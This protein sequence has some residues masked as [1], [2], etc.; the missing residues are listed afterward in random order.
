MTSKYNR[1]IEIN[2][3]VN[4]SAL[5]NILECL[6]SSLNLEFLRPDPSSNETYGTK[7]NI[8]AH[9]YISNDTKFIKLTNTQRK[10]VIAAINRMELLAA[11]SII[12][13]GNEYIE[14]LPYADW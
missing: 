10:R 8:I 3:V 9:G 5:Q 11:S 7:L 2:R 14:S 1:K 6:E 12:I 4:Q 13:E